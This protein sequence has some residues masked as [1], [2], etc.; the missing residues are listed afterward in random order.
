MTIA[1]V[2]P[3]PHAAQ[4]RFRRWQQ[5][6][7]A[8]NF[9]V[10]G[11]N[12]RA[13]LSMKQ[14]E[15]A[16]P[17]SPTSTPTTDQIFAKNAGRDL[18][19]NALDEAK[20]ISLL[21]AELG[22]LSAADDRF[23]A[24][25]RLKFFPTATAADAI[26]RFVRRFD[27]SKLDSYVLED[28][29]A[30]RK[31]V[32][33]LARHKGVH[34]RS[35]VLELLFSCLSD[36]DPY[37][38]E[39]AIWA[40]AEVDAQDERALQ[41][42]T[43]VLSADSRVAK[44][45]AIHTLLRANHTP[46]LPALRQF[47]DDNDLAT[48][49]AARAACSVLASDEEAMQ[50]VIQ[51]LRSPVLNVRRAAIE[52]I[53]LSRYVP[54]LDAICKCP[55]SLVLRAR[56]A[57]VLLEKGL[58]GDTRAEQSL[59]EETARLVDHLIW[60]NP[61]HLDLLGMTKDTRKARAPD[62]NIRQLY[63]NDA[64][65]AYLACRTLVEDFRGN[66]N[67]H[68]GSQLLKSYNDLGYFDYFGAYHVYKTLGWLK[69]APAYSFL[70]ENATN[71][72]P[73]FFNHQAGAIT[74]LAELGNGDAIDTLIEVGKKSDIWELKYACLISSERLGDSGRLREAFKSDA[75]WLIRS[76]AKCGLDFSHL[77]G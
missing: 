42:V 15:A 28:R 12:R 14:G 48:A 13:S 29:V 69:Y 59:D 31:A 8:R 22:S 5:R 57:R 9:S 63:K 52:D 65:E 23:I 17:P 43:S 33:S 44:R 49:S 53:T 72:P 24:A 64:L 32:E 45:V 34:H 41:S 75:D 56:T 37:M 47:V 50:P 4:S 74:A 54:A 26:I 19:F 68:I 1:Y 30:R 10:V 7:A 46:A 11:R 21:D 40:L 67:D 66:E 58:R 73:R 16:G 77:D 70:L 71:L 36:P 25:E 61:V 62:R 38:V 76:R 27:T 35:R 60:D 20:A 55:N 6:H 18:F 2:S 51:F 3:I 39:V